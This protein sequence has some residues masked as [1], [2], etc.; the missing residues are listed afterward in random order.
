[1]GGGLV[2]PV[3]LLVKLSTLLTTVFAAFS[4][5]V[6]T[7]LAKSAPGRVGNVTGVPPL[8]GRGIG[9]EGRAWPVLAAQGR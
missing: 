1:L 7:V 5:P 9:V 4:T 6:T 8:E 3:I 2:V